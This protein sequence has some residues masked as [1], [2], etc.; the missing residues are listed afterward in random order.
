ML[1]IVVFIL[2]KPNIA[3]GVLVDGHNY[4]IYFL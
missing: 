3:A 2:L 4:G 1:F